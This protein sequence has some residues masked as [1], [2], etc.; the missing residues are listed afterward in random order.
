[1]AMM[2]MLFWILSSLS[3]LTEKRERERGPW[4]GFERHT[5]A[6]SELGPKSIGVTGNC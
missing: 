4:L 1:M 5:Q 2:E 3:N 6:A